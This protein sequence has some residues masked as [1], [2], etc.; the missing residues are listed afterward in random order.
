MT[1]YVVTKGR[2]IHLN[3]VSGFVTV[4][5]IGRHQRT[6][7]RETGGRL[8]VLLGA[9]H[10]ECPDCQ[11]ASELIASGVCARDCATLT[12]KRLFRKRDWV[13]SRRPT[14]DP[15]TRRHKACSTPY[16]QRLTNST[17]RENHQWSRF[18]VVC[19]PFQQ[20]QPRTELIA[21]AWHFF[22]PEGWFRAKKP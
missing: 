12:A 1:V 14:H 20:L 10:T 16:S 13:K 5:L 9:E 2:L 4:G 19:C 11:L 22:L 18:D 6:E 3:H 7:V 21:N 15:S 8:G 17:K